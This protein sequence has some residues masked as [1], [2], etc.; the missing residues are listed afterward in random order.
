MRIHRK[1]E[2]LHEYLRREEWLVVRDAEAGDR[3][4]MRSLAEIYEAWWRDLY[5]G[6]GET[7]KRP[8]DPD[9]LF[10]L[11]FRWRVRAAEAGDVES[12][13]WVSVYMVKYRQQFHITEEMAGGR[14][15]LEWQRMA[16]EAGDRYAMKWMGDV[17]TNPAYEDYDETIAVEWYEKSAAAGCIYAMHELA[18][19]YENGIFY[20]KDL[21][22]AL[23]WYE[24]SA[25]GMDSWWDLAR[26]ERKV[27]MEDMVKCVDMHM[28]G[29]PMSAQEADWLM[30]HLTKAEHLIAPTDAAERLL[31]QGTENE[32]L[33]RKLRK[34]K[35]KMNAV[36]QE[37]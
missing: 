25:E 19:R 24:K 10:R 26:S 16:A 7:R 31:Q 14:S 15:S 37:R 11:A 17:Y 3:A 30:E 18:E 27:S 20:E 36:R 34:A 1:E 13:C 23:S 21:D 28:A 8:G 2:E 29:L 22:R 12:M 6:D 32:I 9:D 35:L 4:S 33:V 5:Y